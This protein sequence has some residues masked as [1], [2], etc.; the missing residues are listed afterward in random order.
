[1]VK[2]SGANKNFDHIFLTN[3]VLLL[4]KTKIFKLK[5]LKKNYLKQKQA[6]VHNK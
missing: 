4:S 3:F 1:M 5:L 2:L 6:L